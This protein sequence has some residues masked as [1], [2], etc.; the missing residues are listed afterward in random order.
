MYH[1][2]RGL[3]SYLREKLLQEDFF[4]I[5][6]NV[7]M[8]KTLTRTKT[9]KGGNPLKLDVEAPRKRRVSTV[10]ASRKYVVKFVSGAKSIATGWLKTFG[11]ENAVGFGLPEVDDRYHIW[12]VPL[13]K[14]GTKERIGEVVIDAYTSLVS[15]SETTA[16]D[17]LE[18]RLL[19]RKEAEKLSRNGSSNATQSLGSFVRNTVILGDSEQ[20]LLD[21]PSQ[22]VD[23]IF[24]S[25]PYYNA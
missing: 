6:Y 20:V 12:R 5:S 1:R 10:A 17:V 25:P 15:A 8:L 22:S 23:L 18:A 9:T 4:P 2:I 7:D 14:S 19:G 24:T 11:L 13:V 21:M 16:S 3:H